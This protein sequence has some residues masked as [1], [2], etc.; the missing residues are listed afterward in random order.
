M[1]VR[2]LR[3]MNSIPRGTSLI[4]VGQRLHVAGE[5]VATRTHVVRG[6]ETLSVIARRYGMSL[7]E[8]RAANGM[9]PDQSL[10]RTGQ[11]LRVADR[12]SAVDRVVHVVRTGDTLLRIALSYGVRLADLLLHNG[13]R[14]DSTIYPGQRI[15]IP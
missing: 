10:I 1:S 6:G 8:L 14:Q 7:T 12:P 3:E 15:R 5:T 2:R 13:L 4:R 9:S 11:K